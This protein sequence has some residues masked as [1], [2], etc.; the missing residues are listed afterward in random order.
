M[1]TESTV[2]NEAIWTALCACLGLAP[3]SPAASALIQPAYTEPENAPR[4]PR[5]RDVVYYYLETE[6]A[7]AVR[8]QMQ[9]PAVFTLRSPDGLRPPEPGPAA[10]IPAEIRSF[11]A[12]RLIIVCY[13]PYAEEHAHRIR[14]LLY[15]DGNGKPRSI[16][17]AAGIYPIPDPPQALILREPAGSLWRRRA[18]LSVSLRVRDEI[19]VSLPAVNTAPDILMSVR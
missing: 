4:P 19:A 14:A 13:G 12:W 7:A 2:M 3:D 10:E 1:N 15:L 6:D 8:P 11:P 18:E 9:V 16:L 5:E 17:R